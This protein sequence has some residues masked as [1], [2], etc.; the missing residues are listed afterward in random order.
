[1]M[2]CAIVTSGVIGHENWQRFLMPASML[3]VRQHFIA[4]LDFLPA[5]ARLQTGCVIPARR[6]PSALLTQCKSIVD[7][8]GDEIHKS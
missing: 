1:M 4:M 3:C 2:S 6:G 5:D 7:G 8:S